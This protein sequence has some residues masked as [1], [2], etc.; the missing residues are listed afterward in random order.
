MGRERTGVLRHPNEREYPRP[1]HFLQFTSSI[2]RVCDFPMFRSRPA[3]ILFATVLTLALLIPIAYHFAVQRLKV[4]VEQ[5]LGARAQVGDVV[6]RW[7]ALELRDVVV[8]AA[9]G[10]PVQD[11]MR[12]R[13]VRVVPALTSLLR[14]D[15]AVRELRLEGAYLS[16]LRA[17]N[18]RVRLLPS[19][20]EPA[21]AQAAVAEPSRVAQ[22]EASAEQASAA[23]TRVIQFDS[24][25]LADGALDYCDATVARKPHCIALRALDGRLSDLRIPTLDAESALA[26]AGT[27]TGPTRDGRLALDGRLTL[28][29]RDMDLKLGLTGVDLRSVEPYLVKA[30]DAGVKRGVLDLS[31][32]AKVAKRRLDAPGQLTLSEL[33]LV[34][35]G[36]SALGLPR[37]LVVSALKD[38]SG[39]IQVDFTLKGNLDDPKFSLNEVM[40]SRFAAAVAEGLGVSIGGLAEG[41]G[42]AAGGIGESLRKLFGN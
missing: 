15:I 7:N 3:R 41:V 29:T 32:H 9:D 18:G 38:R 37:A 1:R 4:S 35:Y 24:I 25:V 27:V 36:H 33:E 20:L 16:M 8:R 17:R 5:G 10:W 6:V 31:M 26:L 21:E 12:A 34:E 40:A 13:V 14:G 22:S 2:N 23:P 28:A 42:K 19:V 39:R 11:E 30:A